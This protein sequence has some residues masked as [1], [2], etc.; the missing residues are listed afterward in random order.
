MCNFAPILRTYTHAL[1]VRRCYYETCR[2]CQCVVM[3]VLPITS[4]GR[5]V[6]VE[7]EGMSKSKTPLP[8]LAYTVRDLTF[9]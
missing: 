3:S 5:R 8:P 9:R 2:S 7:D 1:R 4:F 6:K